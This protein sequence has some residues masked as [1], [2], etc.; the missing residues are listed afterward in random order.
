MRVVK[1][2]SGAAA[3]NARLNAFAVEI[4]EYRLNEAAQRV[5][6]FPA[7]RAIVSVSY[8]HLDVY[9]RQ[10]L[11][12][13]G[14]RAA[15]R[16]LFLLPPRG[17]DVQQVRNTLKQAFPEGLI[18]D[19]RETHP[20]ITRGLE[21]ST[22]FLSLISLIALIVGALGVAT[23]MH[24][25][26]QQKMDTIAVLKCLGA[27]SGQVLRI[28]LAQTLA[29]GLAGGVLGVAFGMV[30]QRAFPALIGRFFPV[31]PHMGLD[32]VP[33]AQGLA[34]GILTTCLLYTSR[35]V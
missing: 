13:L 10:G 21:R 12:G 32:L 29:L 18:A 27:R 25:H 2:R 5:Q 34:I 31:P 1:R 16:Y 4:G 26:L 30:V 8:T 7:R 35:C 9:K 19:Y 24:A 22:T 20:I 3:D 33:A 28:Y 23:A 6:R 11:I 15:E 17:P 14:S